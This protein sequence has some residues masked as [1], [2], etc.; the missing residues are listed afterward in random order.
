MAVLNWGAVYRM[1]GKRLLPANP[2]HG[3]SIPREK[4]A[5]RPLATEERYTALLAVADKADPQGRL[6]LL[7]ALAR[8]T[9]RRI[10]ALANL[11]A[12]DVLLS[13]EQMVTALAEVGA[14]IAWAEE[15]P[16][17]ALRFSAKFDKRGY[18]SVGAARQ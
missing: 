12:T 15:W 6:R 7:L 5:K 14:P 11:R 1:G 13:R 17:G 9:G 3:A 8:H 18:E 10:N 2:L 4:N 16:H